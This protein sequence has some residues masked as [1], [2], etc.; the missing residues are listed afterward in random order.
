[1]LTRA[2]NIVEIATITYAIL[3]IF[4]NAVQFVMLSVKTE[5]VQRFV[6]QLE[7]FVNLSILRLIASLD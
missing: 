7:R 5:L 4:G 1:M 6:L 2:K 3:T